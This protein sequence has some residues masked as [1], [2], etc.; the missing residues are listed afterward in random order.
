MPISTTPISRQRLHRFGVGLG[1]LVRVRNGGAELN[2]R[3]VRSVPDAAHT[4]L[5]VGA[6]HGWLAR[7][8]KHRFPDRIVYGLDSP[9]TARDT[10]PAPDPSDLDKYFELETDGV[11]PPLEAGSI[12]TIIYAD[13]LSRWTDPLAVLEAHRPLLSTAGTICCSVPNVQH[14]KVVTQLIRGVFRYA[15]NS[16]IDAGHVHLFTATGVIQLLLD[17]GFAPK[18]ADKI[19]SAGSDDI[20]AAGAPLFEL[21]GVGVQDLE[22]HLRISEIVLTGKP[23]VAVPESEEEAL[24]FVVCVNDDDQLD[25][26][27]GSSP[28]FAPGSPH[29]LLVF[30]GCASAAEGLN[31]GIEAARHDLVVFVHQDVYLPK[32]WPARLV[33]QWHQVQD[34]TAPVGIAGVFGVAKRTVPFDAVGR[35]VHCDRLLEEGAL[36]ATVDGLDE[37]L[38]VVP[39][40]TPLRFDPALGWHL[41]GTDAALQAQQRGTRVVVLDAPCHH[42]TLSKRVPSAYR[43]SERVLARKWEQLLPIHTNLSSIGAWLLETS[44]EGLEAAG[45]APVTEHGDDAEA[46]VMAGIV[47]RLQ[48]ERAALE[49]ELERARLEV[50]SMQASPFWKARQ[51]VLAIGDRLGRRR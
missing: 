26:N 19:Q 37:V 18:I 28:C 9:R 39:R 7:A 3:L 14:Q 51:A 12:D 16:P 15:Q 36:P 6:T 25:A 32:G 45:D 2:E 47:Q 20:M 40:S 46:T 21:L 27:L 11:L 43:H 5:Q 23:L 10:A 24:T 1:S 41:Y 42:N 44:D 22:R 30:R 49:T 4:I 33:S 34:A 8:L 35:I 13:S 29:E 50:A 48:G 31:A 17:A 38:M